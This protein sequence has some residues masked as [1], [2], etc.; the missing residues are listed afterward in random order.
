MPNFP[1]LPIVGL[2][3]LHVLFSLVALV[4][5]THLKDPQLLPVRAF[6]VPALVLSV[7]LGSALSVRRIRQGRRLAVVFLAAWLAVLGLAIHSDYEFHRQ[8]RAVLAASGD[9]ACRLAALGA[10]LVVGYGKV[11][12]VRELARR[13][14]IAGVFVTRRNAA[15]KSLEALRVELAG[16]Q[17]LRRQARLPPLII[18]SD[19]EGG[20]VSR[21]SPPLPWQPS[22]ASLLASEQTLSQAEKRA[23]EYGAEQGRA[24]AALGVNVNFSPVV[25]LKPAWASGPLDFHTHIAD[26]A[27]SGDP[28]TV[29][30]LA[31]AYGQ[32]LLSQGVLPTLKHFPGLS[33]VKEDTHH[34]SGH[35]R[36]S[37]D[38]LNT[39]DWRPFREIP[40][41]IPALLMVGHVIVDAVDPGLPASFSQ[42]VLGGLLRKEWKYG[43]ILIG[44]DMTMASAYNRGLCFASVGALNGGM[45]LLLVSYDWEKVYPILDC[46]LEADRRG[47]LKSLEASRVRLG[48]LLGDTG[49]V[50]ASKAGFEPL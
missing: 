13:G 9:E 4:L 27:I 48:R 43:G 11:E 1:R 32:G 38:E 45:D 35:L 18:T 37:L 44:D 5:A 33:G 26:R 28:E 3:L 8:K 21:L 25:D 10:H 29:T 24:L 34:F 39:R 22:L 40:R 2:S 17:E 16:L 7:L 30:R 42:K 12:E 19:Q 20:L 50:Q 41:H 47:E 36:H 14:F 15:G 46:L 23:A 31:L 6:E 49:A